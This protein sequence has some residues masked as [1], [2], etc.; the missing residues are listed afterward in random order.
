MHMLHIDGRISPGREQ[1]FFDAWNT[2]ILPRMK[3][4]DGFVSEMLLFEDC[5]N[6]GIDISFWSTQKEAEQYLQNVLEKT[7]CDVE[8]LLEGRVTVYSCGCDEAVL[9]SFNR[10]KAA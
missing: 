7:I 3:E 2:D 9:Q 10:R 5:T 8:C 4:Q 1:E 6:A